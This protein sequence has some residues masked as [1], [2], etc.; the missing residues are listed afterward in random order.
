MKKVLY[1]LFHRSVVVGVSLLAQIITLAVMVTFFSEYT[2]AFYWC[3]I[4]LRS[5]RRFNPLIQLYRNFLRLFAPL[6]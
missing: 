4:S 2:S 3:C 6:M 1:I 5:R